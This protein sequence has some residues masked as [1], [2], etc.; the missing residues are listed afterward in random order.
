MAAYVV[1]A[2]DVPMRKDAALEAPR[3]HSWLDASGLLGL[4]AVAMAGIQTIA[5]QATAAGDVETPFL[6]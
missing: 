4:A 3:R 2:C 1:E 6:S 5:I